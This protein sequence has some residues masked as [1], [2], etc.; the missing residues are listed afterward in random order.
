MRHE[1]VLLTEVIEQLQ[2]TP[3]DTVIDCTTGDG[4]HSEAMLK[5]IGEKGTL[6]AIDADPESLL[7]A[8]K[9]LHPWESQVT[10]HRGNFA[11]LADIAAE[12]HVQQVNGILMDYG[13]SSPQFA[14]R[15]RG[16][17]FQ[18]DEPLDM[19]YD[20]G[21]DNQVT[22]KEIVNQYP[23][24]ELARIFTEYGE[25]NQA[26]RIA[27]AIKEARKNQKIETTGQLVD[28][29]LGNYRNEH[30]MKKNKQWGGGI[31]PATKIFQALRIEVNKELDVIKQ[32]LPQA[33][34]LLAPGGRLA[35][36]T[37]HSLEDRY[38]KHYF[39]QQRDNVHIITKKPIVPTQQ[40][41]TTNSRSRSA[42]LRVIE[43]K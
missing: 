6:L 21:Q 11:Q 24:D 28:I 27:Q 10:F 29:I 31:H 4:G 33:I 42:K 5:A 23:I 8:K 18:T 41:V 34:E 13:W 35:V 3:G 30:Q 19:R 25:D 43:K 12:H 14:E 39:K 36:I 2:L 37:F 26:E 38:V 40:E 32:V 9:F 16:F 17:S 7:R 20:A 15:N 22:A 1:P